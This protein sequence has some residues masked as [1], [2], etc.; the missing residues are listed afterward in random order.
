MHD[1]A[2]ARE[3]VLLA[4]TIELER[5]MPEGRSPP[6]IPAHLEARYAAAINEGARIA[7]ALRRH[8]SNIEYVRGLDIVAAALSGRTAEARRLDRIDD[9][10]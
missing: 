9:L 5:V 6:P 7:L 10:E 4:G 8:E 3:C 2:A 1:H